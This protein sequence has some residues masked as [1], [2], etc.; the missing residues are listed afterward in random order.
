MPVEKVVF[1]DE[2]V[3]SDNLPLDTVQVDSAHSDGNAVEIDVGEGSIERF[4]AKIKKFRNYPPTQYFY[5]AYGIFIYNGW[6]VEK[7]KIIIDYARE[8][9]LEVRAWSNDES[10]INM[11]VVKDPDIS[12]DSGWDLYEK[13][14]GNFDSYG[15][16]SWYE[17]EQWG[18]LVYTGEDVIIEPLNS[19]LGI[20][21]GKDN[22][23]VVLR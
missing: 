2:V 8:H 13:M 11:L 18:I 19:G 10:G 4:I 1:D 23:W 22:E 5:H 6:T 21:I 16:A 20:K 15:L 14:Q 9:N 7:A 3:L 12:E 17:F